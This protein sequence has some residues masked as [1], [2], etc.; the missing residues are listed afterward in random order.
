MA[1]QQLLLL[2]GPPPY[3]GSGSRV[4][5]DL[6]FK[7]LSNFSN[8][9]IHYSDLPVFSPLYN[10]DG[11]LGPLSHIRTILRLSRVVIRVP[12][13]AIVV[14]CGTSDFC[15]S[16]G[17]AIAFCSRL[18]RRRCI[19]ILTGGR[20]VFWTQRLPKLARTICLAMTQ[21]FA[22]FVM[23]T[24]VSRNDLPSRLR[25]RAVVVKNCRP[26]PP[27]PPSPRRIEDGRIHFA[28]VSGPESSTTKKPVKG[29]DVLLDA[30][31]HLRAALGLDKR[32]K[33]HLY[34]PIPLS[35]TE[36]VEQTPNIVAHGLL[37]TEQLRTS[38]RQH[39]VLAFS[40]RAPSEGHPG[41]I[42]EA[43]MAGLPVIASDLPGPLEIVGHE[44]NGLVVRTDDWNALA[45]AMNRLAT[46][47]ELRRRLGSGAW[48]SASDF[49]QEKILPEFAAALGLLPSPR[50]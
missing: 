2:I 17:L 47:H 36:R 8:L 19:A 21:A 45:V 32:I 7:Y 13:S 50:R 43:F 26:R 41:V 42:I 1:K 48:A 24:E 12:R 38:L 33:L 18:F 15:F 4:K 14:V 3:Q 16:Y 30:F 23:E 20:G 10:A 35:L 11:T 40:S 6:L 44:I 37:S 34:G 46:D 39:D 29:L 22:T 27:G 28:F 5:F 25:T 9:T 31:D 49:D